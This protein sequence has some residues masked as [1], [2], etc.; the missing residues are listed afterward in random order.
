MKPNIYIPEWKKD[1]S[2]GVEEIDHQHE[3]FLHLIH[4]FDKRLNQ[5]LDDHLVI[6]HLDEIMLYTK[7]HF[8]SEENLMILHAYPDIEEHKELHIEIIQNLTNNLTLYKSNKIDL[9]SLVSFLVDW[10]INH[11]I[12]EDKKFANFIKTQT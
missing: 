7:F 4:R 8:C 6:R 9:E 11:T 12:Q 2:L 10:F 3:Y 1:Y 5:D